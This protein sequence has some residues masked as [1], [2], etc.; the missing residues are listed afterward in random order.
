MVLLIDNYDSFVY[1]LARYVAEL[2][3]EYQVYRNDK[4]QIDDIITIAPSHIVIS[5]GP[6]TPNEAGI[7]LA[8]VSTFFDKI[9]L[10]GVCLG[11]QAIAQALGGNV[12]RAAQPKHGKSS[13]VF[14][15]GEG[16]F[17]S[18][19]NPLTVGRYHSLIVEN[20]SLPSTLKITGLTMDHEIMGIE[21]TDFP[22]FGVQFHPESVLTDS[23]HQM[24]RN[25]LQVC[26]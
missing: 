7:S 21:H 16:I 25:F 18:L 13:Q 23:G 14:H 8:I 1:N 17:S 9:P 2:G 26:T 19:P 22:V 3:H 11:H 6:C 12:V 10:L 15:D 20:Q 5:P 24:L 4:L